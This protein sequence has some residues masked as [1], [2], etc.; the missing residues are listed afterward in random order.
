MKIDEYMK[1]ISQEIDK[2]IIKSYNKVRLKE[3]I[4]D[5]SISI[6]YDNYCEKMAAYLYNQDL[7]YSVDYV[8]GSGYL[9]ASD[10]L[11]VN[12]VT[13]DQLDHSFRFFIQEIIQKYF[14][15]MAIIQKVVVELTDKQF[16]KIRAKKTEYFSIDSKDQDNVSEKIF[17]FE[18]NSIS[19]FEHVSDNFSLKKQSNRLDLYEFK[20]DIN[21]RVNISDSLF[22]EFPFFYK[23]SK[24]FNI[25]DDYGVTI[26]PNMFSDYIV[27]YEKYF[28]DIENNMFMNAD[29]YIKDA[30]FNDSINYA[31]LYEETVSNLDDAILFLEKHNIIS[32][33]PELENTS[34]DD[35]EKLKQIEKWISNI[36]KR[37]GK[38]INRNYKRVI[39]KYNK[40]VDIQN[41]LLEVDK[42]GKEEKL[43][44]N[45][46]FNSLLHNQFFS[47]F[48]NS[49]IYKAVLK[50][51]DLN[52]LYNMNP[53]DFVDYDTCE[54]MLK[55]IYFLTTCMRFNINLNRF[56]N[57]EYYIAPNME[58]KVFPKNPIIVDGIINSNHITIE[59]MELINCIFGNI[60]NT[61]LI[62]IVN[63]MNNDSEL[64]LNE[65]C[66]EYI[67]HSNNDWYT[68]QL[69]NQFDY[70]SEIKYEKIFNDDFVSYLK[71]NHFSEP[72]I[73]TKYIRTNSSYSLLKRHKFLSM[74]LV[75][76]IYKNKRF[77]ESSKIDTAEKQTPRATN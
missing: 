52:Y 58:E 35:D 59:K 40:Y 5:D 36:G 53:E 67:M 62:A 31:S 74:Y 44:N 48:S 39:N 33:F 1:L 12:S 60:Y 47:S 45:I 13:S 49:N 70:K 14:L 22:N 54:T 38:N 63:D 43:I 42:K 61:R 75:H 18:N 8:N 32:Y 21:Y 71:L 73:N 27:F 15:E 65:I 20:E 64:S 72:L 77:F 26:V 4:E 23:L 56:E 46:L 76:S 25:S 37:I 55:D 66:D 50:R 24:D 28:N 6:C 9:T 68:K 51:V 2:L 30:K 16:S 11:L 29:D 19:L 57:I 10:F 3:D 41:K 7:I 69:K 34:L 17:E